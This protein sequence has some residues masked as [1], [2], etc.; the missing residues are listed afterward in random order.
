MI[1]KPSMV[2]GIG[3]IS[4]LGC[5]EATWQQ[6]LAGM[7][8]IKIQQP[9]PDLSAYPLALIDCQPMD[10]IALLYRS[11][12]DALKDADLPLPLSD[13]PVVVG[14]SRSQQGKWEQ[15]LRQGVR[16]PSPQLSD[17][18]ATLPNAPAI[19]AARYL[20]TTAPVLAPMAACATG[21]WAIAQGHALLQQGQYQRA[22][23]GAVETPLT[24]LTLAG[25]AQMGA[26]ATTGCY[27]F[28]RQR[29]GLALGEAAVVLVLE[30]AE[31]ASQRSTHCYGQVLG[32]GMTADGYHI[33]AP[34]TN[35]KAA[36]AAIHQCLQHSGLIAS[37]IDYIHAHGT[38][39]RLNDQNEA[40]LIQTLFPS[41]LPISSTKG[42]TGHTLG[43]SGVLG[44]AFCLLAM[45]DRQLPPCV[46]LQ[47]PE[48]DLDFVMAARP[49]AIRHSLCLSFGFGGQN[50]AIALR[51]YSGYP[52]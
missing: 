21:L 12:A 26:L 17:W 5:R 44:V 2:T 41:Q 48:F 20:R 13:C 29:Q 37:D 51:N 16:Q 4:A 22:I 7:S 46:G 6:L 49:H 28:D 36:I 30:T 34:A 10:N 32:A 23:V 39:T 18:W 43:V 33:S 15:L 52:A 45:R 24:P 27:P 42:A 11:L 25:F 50:A 9:F 1:D 19:A 47:D 14:S 3:L 31:S 35:A 38:A 40:H 8:G